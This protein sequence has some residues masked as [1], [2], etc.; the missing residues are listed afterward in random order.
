MSRYRPNPV[1]NHADLRASATLFRFVP[2]R[3]ITSVTQ[4]FSAEKRVARG[5]GRK[6]AVTQCACIRII[7]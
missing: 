6:E 7:E 4:H 5:D 3:F 1:Q 2:R